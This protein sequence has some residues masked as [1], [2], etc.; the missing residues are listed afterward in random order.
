MEQGNT[1]ITTKN[2]N[3]SFTL[4]NANKSYFLKLR[5]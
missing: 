1:N 2:K 5:F 3:D 4:A